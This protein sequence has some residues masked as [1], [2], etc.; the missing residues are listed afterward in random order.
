MF[1]ILA[2]K[3]MA[4]EFLAQPRVDSRGGVEFTAEDDLGLAL[5]YLRTLSNVFRWAPD[6]LWAILARRTLPAANGHSQL[7]MTFFSMVDVSS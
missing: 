5:Y 1:L 2:S 7:S 4:L 3:F 6:A